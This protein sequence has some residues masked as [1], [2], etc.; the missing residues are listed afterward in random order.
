MLNDLW[1]ILLLL[2]L[3]FLFLEN[4]QRGLKN[5][6]TLEH[7]KLGQAPWK[8]PSLGAVYVLANVELSDM[9]TNSVREDCRPVGSLLV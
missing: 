1:F 9:S 6:R 3:L 5:L 8:N 7:S 4:Q 2:L